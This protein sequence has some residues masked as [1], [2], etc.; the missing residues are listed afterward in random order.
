MTT[1]ARKMRIVHYLY[2]E[3]NFLNLVSILFN[4]LTG[5]IFSDA[6][7]MLLKLKDLCQLCH[8]L[9]YMLFIKSFPFMKFIFCM[10]ANENANLEGRK[11]NS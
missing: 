6:I 4:L 11:Q 5:T 7:F 8:T 10:K 9:Y 1:A 2:N 3:F